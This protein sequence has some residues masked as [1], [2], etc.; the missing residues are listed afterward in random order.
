MSWWQC[1]VVWQFLQQRARQELPQSC[2]VSACLWHGR[3]R[4]LLAGKVLARQ[5][6]AP[7]SVCYRVLPILRWNYPP[8][9]FQS[10]ILLF[11]EK[12]SKPSST[13]WN[14]W[15]YLSDLH[16]RS[17]L[18]KHIQPCQD[19]QTQHPW[20]TLSACALGCQSLNSEHPRW[21]GEQGCHHLRSGHCFWSILRQPTGLTLVQ[22]CWPSLSL[23]TAWPQNYH[24]TA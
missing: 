5:A 9:Q 4:R 22:H 2:W 18:S 3:P 6:A 15:K 13:R 20:P 17:P 16:L 23:Q 11:S 19:F 14:G 7:S 10:L 12:T 24:H 1:L 21:W 8:C